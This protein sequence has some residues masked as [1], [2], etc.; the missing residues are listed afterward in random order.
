MVTALMASLDYIGVLALEL[1][2]SGD[3]LVA[4]EFAPR[5]HNSGHWTPQGAATSQF[6][7][8]L[9]AILGLP[10]GP[11]SALGAAA[12][13][14]FIGRLP[15]LTE[16]LSIPQ[17]RLHAYGK[18]PRPGR[19]VGHATVHAPDTITCQQLAGRLLEMARATGDG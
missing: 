2:Q 9:R 7:N 13:V 19:K 5:V 16:V 17:A 14:N 4:S 10:L 12:T 3:R 1:F 8:H 6:E 15:S 18:V 11:T